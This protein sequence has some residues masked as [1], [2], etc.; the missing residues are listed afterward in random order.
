M[1][2]SFRRPL[3]LGACHQQDPVVKEAN[4]RYL[5]MRER[6]G[7][8][9][10][11]RLVVEDQRKDVLVGSGAHPQGDVGVLLT[12]HFQDGRERKQGDRKD[13]AD[14]EIAVARLV[15]AP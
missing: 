6:H 10:D 11:V 3:A 7:R 2:D 15:R 13:R 14:A 5:R 4:G 9:A 12:V 1:T 8:E